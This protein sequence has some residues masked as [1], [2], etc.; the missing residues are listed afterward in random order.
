MYLIEWGSRDKRILKEGMVD[1]GRQIEHP[2][3][4][5]NEKM[6]SLRSN[7]DFLMARH[8]QSNT[9]IVEHIFRTMREVLTQSQPRDSFH[10]VYIHTMI[11]KHS[12]G[13]SRLVLSSNH[14]IENVHNVVAKHGK[15]SIEIDVWRNISIKAERIVADEEIG[16]HV[17]HQARHSDL[18]RFDQEIRRNTTLGL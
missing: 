6:I 11:N 16:Y 10:L 7:L 3:N 14:T 4:V 5:N 12:H 9:W 8:H 17:Q 15:S 13:R 2:I 1:K 18:W